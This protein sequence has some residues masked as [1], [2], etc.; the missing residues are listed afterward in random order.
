MKKS[1]T[2]NHII[3]IVS[4]E[5]TKWINGW[6]EIASNNKDFV[7]FIKFEELINDSKREF[8]K[9]LNFYEIELDEKLINKI[10]ESNKGKKDMVTNMN[11]QKILP[12]AISSNF[13]SGK[14]GNWKIEFTKENI[15]YAKKVLGKSLID[16]KYEKDLNWKI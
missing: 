12:W 16:L 5:V 15:D 2:I 11:E 3:Y 4:D 8:K 7:L 1:D 10:C 13:R 6:F 14:I 9:I